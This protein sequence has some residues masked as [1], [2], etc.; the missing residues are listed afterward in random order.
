MTGGAGA[1]VCF[2]SG[3][4]ISKKQWISKKEW[5][6]LPSLLPSEYA[7]TLHLILSG[8]EAGS[9]APW[10][11]GVVST[12]YLSLVLFAVYL[13]SSELRLPVVQYSTAAPAPPKVGNEKRHNSASSWG[14][15]RQ[16]RIEARCVPSLLLTHCYYPLPETNFCSQL[17]VLFATAASASTPWPPPS[18]QGG[19]GM[20]DSDLFARVRAAAQRK[21][22]ER[23]QR[24]DYF[25][26]QLNTQ[27]MMVCVWGGHGGKGGHAGRCVR[28]GA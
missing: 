18:S 9:L 16:R 11:L 26:L 4:L 17:L 19:G 5:H 21:A 24:A 3:T 7:E 10:K 14:C 2:Q 22:A 12:G 15:G 20:D 27:G 8:L 6:P 13:N 28:A 1:A 25:P 23:S